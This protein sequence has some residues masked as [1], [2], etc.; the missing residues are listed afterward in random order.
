MIKNLLFCLIALLIG[1]K[2]FAQDSTDKY[3]IPLKDAKLKLSS[4][5]KDYSKITLNSFEKGMITPV[6]TNE[7]VFGAVQSRNPNAI[8]YDSTFKAKKNYLAPVG[9]IIVL[10]IG[11]W[12]ISRY[13]SPQPWARI[14][15][16]SIGEN[17]SKMWVWDADHFETNQFLHPYHG[18]TYF[19][20]ARSSGLNFW[21]SAPYALGGSLMWELFME[22]NYPSKNDLITTTLGGISLGEM[23]YR[24]SSLVIDERKSGSE[25]FWREVGAFLIAPTRGINRLLKGDVSRYRPKSI[26]EIEPVT[27]TLSAGPSFIYETGGIY[28]GNG[29]LSLRLDLYYGNPYTERSRKPYD[30]FNVKGMISIGTQPLLSQVNVYG[31]LFGKNYKYKANQQ[32]LIGMFQYFDY[33]SNV[34]YKIAA[35]SL[36]GGVVYKYP[37]ISNVSFES[38][39]H[40][41]FIVLGGGSN[42]KE[43]FKY[44]ADGTAYRDYN[45]AVGFAYKFE[46]AILLKDKG[47]LFLGLYNY[48]MYTVDG[49]DGDDNL[50]ILTPRLSINLSPKTSI[51]FEYNNYIRSSHYK[52][53]NDFQTKVYEMKLIISNTF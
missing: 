5:E 31:L 34:Y 26:Y 48:R 1:I 16:N 7:S 29:N 53:Y 42:I 43:A 45:F 9:E 3:E 37:T 10:N 18:N 23:T 24:L 51:G 46:S 21:E 52:K 14:S 8:K 32:M 30:F 50:L 12:S 35:N 19:N 39:M 4:L 20:F 41:A 49:A 13:L 40:A 15:I 17:F 2:A 33:Y 27:G 36:G 6:D 28:K 25:R 22:T 11:V 44:E 38:S 47:Q